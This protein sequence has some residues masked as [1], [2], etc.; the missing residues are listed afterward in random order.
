[1]TFPAQRPKSLLKVSLFWTFFLGSTTFP[2]LPLRAAAL[3]LYFSPALREKESTAPPLTTDLEPVGQE[4][5][6]WA[7]FQLSCFIPTLPIAWY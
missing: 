3:A 4:D 7:P 1:M 2:L 6:F 5:G